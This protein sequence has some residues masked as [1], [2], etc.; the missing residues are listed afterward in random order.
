MENANIAKN[1][2]VIDDEGLVTRSLQRLLK[3]EGYNPVVATSGQEAIKKC[4]DLDFDLI[5]S[6]VRMPQLDGIE[7]IKR[8]RQLLK[9]LGKKPIPEILI[10]GYADEDSY[11]RGLELRVR[12]YIYKPFDRDVFLK[13]IQTYL[14]ARESTEHRE[15]LATDIKTLINNFIKEQS[16]QNKHF[17]LNKALPIMG[18]C[19]TYVPEEVIIAAGFLPYR[20]MG[21]PIPLH[22]SKTYLSGNLC[23]SVQSILECALNGDYNFLDGMIIGASTDATKRL[24]D[25]WTRYINTP[26][27]YLLDMPKFINQNALIHY[28]ESLRS[29][30]EELEK[31][32]KIRINDGDLKEAIFICN[33]TRKLLADLN[34]FR[35]TDNPPITSQQFL[36]ICKLAMMSN[37]EGFNNSLEDLIHQIK[38]EENKKEGFRILL[39]GS[40]QDQTWLLDIIEEKGGLVVCEDFCTRLRYFSGLVEEDSNLI[41]AIAERYL[42]I[43]PA[44]ANLVSLDQR[45]NYL[46]S[47]VKEFNIDGVIYY[48][49]KFDDPYLFEF[50]DLKEVFSSNHIPVLR[51]ETEH[52]TSAMGQIMT[53]VQAFIE[54]LKLTRSKQAR[55][56]TVKQ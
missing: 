19:N 12:D 47:L 48:V 44:S 27:N 17:L 52:N 11:K 4:K 5:V 39:T 24:Y 30:I 3:K 38:P 33:K 28:I 16:E 43:K 42:N 25:A 14:G 15:T 45:A 49:L 13:T 50:P 21:A 46:L 51:I 40:F 32:F 35:K 29:L 7:T 2:L 56:A 53:R 31:Y 55:I 9:E 10:T 23:S 1:I 20:V 6:D 54:T 34:N 26:F 22:L 36:E 41:R 18:W 37:K 8:I